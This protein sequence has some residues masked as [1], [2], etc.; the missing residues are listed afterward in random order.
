MSEKIGKDIIKKP[1]K[2][3]L[4]KEI[5]KANQIRVQMLVLEELGKRKM[6]SQELRNFIESLGGDFSTILPILKNSG[7]IQTK[8]IDTGQ[9]GRSF[10]YSLK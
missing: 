1:S 5:E 8:R 9:R 7:L 6:N 10:V 3:K 4:R 2:R